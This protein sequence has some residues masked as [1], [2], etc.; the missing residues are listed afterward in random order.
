[1]KTY[2]FKNVNVIFGVAELTGF[3]DGD[4]VVSIAPASD[5]FG[6]IV[7]AKGEVT[8]SMLNDESVTVTIKLLQTSSSVP[9]L[10]NLY[11]ADKATGAGALPMLITDLET[12]ESFS[13]KSAW[14]KKQP[15]IVRGQNQN[16]YSIEFD[17]DVLIPVVI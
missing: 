5:G 1:M 2:S 16:P 15:E 6:K 11:L 4:D 12:G 14:I 9:I 3:A 10:Q 8:R 17:G 7:G 13:I